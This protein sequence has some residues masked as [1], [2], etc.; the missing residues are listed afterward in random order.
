MFNLSVILEM[1]PALAGLKLKDLR[2]YNFGKNQ[3][4][5]AGYN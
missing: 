5:S 3:Q 4:L 2:Y 1:F